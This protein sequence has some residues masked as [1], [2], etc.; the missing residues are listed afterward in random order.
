MED[1]QPLSKCPEI[2]GY[3][4]V[5]K[6]ARIFKRSRKTI[7]VWFRKGKLRGEKIGKCC[8]VMD[9]DIYKCLSKKN[10]R[11]IEKDL[12][13]MDM[14][15]EDLWILGINALGPLH[16]GREIIIDQ[17]ER[18]V[19]IRILLLN[20]ECPEF[21]KRVDNEE[22]VTKDDGKIYYAKRLID[23][24]KA[25]IA[26][27]RDIKNNSKDN[28]SFEVRIHDNKPTEALVIT[29][30]NPEKSSLGAC[31]YNPYP[32]GKHKRGVQGPHIALTKIHQRE[33]F[34]KWVKKFDDLWNSAKIVELPN[35]LVPQ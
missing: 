32:P 35:Y 23:E 3:S 25:S 24:Y 7:R 28:C 15:H 26:I 1:K 16:Q 29:D 6:C 30:P 22:Y 31:N 19:N 18:G 4:T 2:E 10:Q 27:C 14:A 11:R 8:Y 13:L 12:H 5:D 9:V 33:E 17:L 20:P 21:L 34:N